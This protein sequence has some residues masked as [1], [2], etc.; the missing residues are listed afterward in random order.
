MES[1]VNKM[2]RLAIVF[3]F[4]LSM[5]IIP[6]RLNGEERKPQKTKP[7]PTIIEVGQGTCYP[8]KM[9]MPILNELKKEYAGALNVK[10]VDV[11]YE[12]DA[13]KRYNIRA[14]PFQ[15]FFD[16]TGEEFKRNY[17]LLT[18]EEILNIFKAADIELKK[19]PG[20]KKK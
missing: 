1:N 15:L 12:K 8:C 19:V 20:Q 11:R 10:F 2:L 5:A 14:I 3:F 7:L 17:G 4:L 13:M 6:L 9:M 18:K 16:A